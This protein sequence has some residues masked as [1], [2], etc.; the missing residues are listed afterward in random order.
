MASNQ[1]GYID[2]ELTPEMARLMTE[3]LG[4]RSLVW[5]AGGVTMG[6]CVLGAAAGF[7][8]GNWKMSFP[9]LLTLS[10]DNLETWVVL[11][12]AGVIAAALILAGVTRVRLGQQDVRAGIAKRFD[13][14][15]TI[16]KNRN[17]SYVAGEKTGIHRTT[18]SVLLPGATLARARPEVTEPI[19]TKHVQIENSNPLVSLVT[20]SSARVSF[21]GWIEFATHSHFIFRLTDNPDWQDGS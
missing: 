11:G 6:L 12:L 10:G 16:E 13:G 15:I 20:D 14:P 7:A 8:F 19:F 3:D 2:I 17:D 21:T 9:T 4:L 18:Y 1:R 5:T